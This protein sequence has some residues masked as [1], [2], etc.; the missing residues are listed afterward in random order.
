MA[1]II[2]EAD[3]Y[4]ATCTA[5]D[6]GDTRSAASVTAAGVGFQVLADRTEYLKNRSISAV[7][8]EIMMPLNPAWAIASDAADSID[9]E[10]RAD[11]PTPEVF[12]RQTV[13]AGAAD[14]FIWQQIPPYHN[15]TFSRVVLSLHG[16]AH[17]GAWPPAAFPI[18]RV[19]QTTSV[20]VTTLVGTV[21]DTL[22]Q[23]PYELQH[24]VTL[25]FAAQTMDEDT[26]YWMNLMGEN[27]G[28]NS[29]PGLRIYRAKIL[30]VAA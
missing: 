5:P 26:V 14:G 16:P 21:T 13:A 19:Y 18:L 30:I 3:S 24:D 27:G 23:A 6:D 28:G 25:N 4:N 15:C 22:A 10:L 29:L 17:G 2:T 8:G 12:W 20:G 7:G 11:I 1:T 9:W